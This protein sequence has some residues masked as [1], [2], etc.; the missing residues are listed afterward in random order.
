MK[1]ILQIFPTLT[2]GGLETCVMNIYRTID[3]TE[4]QFDF[5]VNKGDGPYRDEIL[6]KGGRIYVVPQAV[7]GFLTYCKALDSFFC[8]HKGE[9]RV[10]HLHASSLSNLISLYYAKKYGIRVRIIHSHN[11]TLPKKGVR[12]KFHLAIH[13]FFK[14]FVKSVATNYLGCSE[15]ALDW[16]YKGTGIRD[17]AVFIKNCI[18]T[19]NFTFNLERRRKVREEF[20]IQS[21][22]VIGHIGRMVAQKNQLF[23]L[24]IFAEILKLR[25]DSKLMLIGDGCDKDKIRKKGVALGIDNNIIYAG[26]REDVNRLMLAFDIIVMP[27][28]YEGLPV[29]LVEA[30]ASGL[31]LLVSDTISQ[32]SK[33]LDC[34]EFKSLSAPPQE[35]AQ[36]AIRLAENT[37]REDTSAIICEKGFD[38]TETTKQLIQIYN[39]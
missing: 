11:S 19:E 16:M 15:V 30:Q 20:G 6:A 12:G 35:W 32:Q 37:K 23:L 25:P 3:R 39:S 33:L 18:L 38:S 29:C 27:S 2:R 1:R 5:L 22:Y 26:I 7:N 36:S 9:F 24:E 34:V 8:E 31:P 28:L 13:K 14:L 21:E 17:K 10:V 4:Y